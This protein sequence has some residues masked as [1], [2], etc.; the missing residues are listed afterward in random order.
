MKNIQFNQFDYEED[1]AFS[2]V[3]RRK[4]F[5]TSKDSPAQISLT[6]Y[7]GSLKAPKAF[8]AG[9]DKA[10]KSE[11]LFRT[12][13]TIFDICQVDKKINAT[14]STGEAAVVRDEQAYP[15]DEDG[16]EEYTISPCKIASLT[17]IKDSF[18]LDD[19][20]DVLRYLQTDFARR[21]SRA[22]E[23][24]FIN[25][26]GTDEPTGIL[27]NEANVIT[28][29]D[30]ITY[31]DIVKLYFSLKD[32]YA[33]NGVFIVNRKT[34]M[35]LRLIKD[36][37]GRPIW[38]NDNTIF[39]KPVLISEHMPDAVSGNKAIAFGDLSYYWIFIKTPLNVKVLYEL[40]VR[41]LSTGYAAHERLDG[42]LIRKEAVATLQMK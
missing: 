29:G 1:M 33:R 39:S 24:L 14:A 13:G 6:N 35:T 16:V 3:I 20:F 38:N 31:E 12:Y 30:E 41:Q 15:I 11:N 10:V 9:F 42:K 23:K 17:K 8:R 37:N 4:Q 5:S 7:D 26:T 32:E 34:A 22:E 2:N 21:F 40:Y 27:A 28:E 19:K 18:V 25:G 36:S